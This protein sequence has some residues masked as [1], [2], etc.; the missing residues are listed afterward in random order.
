VLLSSERA[1]RRVDSMRLNFNRLRDERVMADEKIQGEVAKVDGSSSGITPEEANELF[2]GNLSNLKFDSESSTFS[3]SPEA[4][5]DVT[6]RLS[7]FRSANGKIQESLR[8]VRELSLRNP[9]LAPALSSMERLLRDRR[10]VT[11]RLLGF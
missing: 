4:P 6:R 3:P 8:S 1:K 10:D 9:R 7:A 5:E 2:G 11:K